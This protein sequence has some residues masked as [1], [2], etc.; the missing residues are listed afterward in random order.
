MH[1][2]WTD[3]RSLFLKHIKIGY[4]V[5]RNIRGLMLMRIEEELEDEL[6]LEVIKAYGETVQNDDETFYD[7]DEMKQMLGL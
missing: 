4:N 2:I 7:H 3:C 1:D 5:S 6:D